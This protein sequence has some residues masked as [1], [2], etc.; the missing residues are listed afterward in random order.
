MV[1]LCPGNPDKDNSGHQL[2]VER[3]YLFSRFEEPQSGWVRKYWKVS[4]AQ[5]QP[6]RD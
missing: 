4:G 5:A 2:L 1:I 3:G 6:A